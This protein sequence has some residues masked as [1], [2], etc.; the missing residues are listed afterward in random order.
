MNQRR[1]LGSLLGIAIGDAL[2]AP[3][4]GGPPPATPLKHY[5]SGGRFGLP[6]GHFT[7]DTLQAIAIARSLI[8]CRGFSAE[9]AMR[10]LLD[11]FLSAGHLF[12]PTSS[13]VF[14]LITGGGSI[15][16]AVIE[17]HQRNGGSRTNGSV[18]RGFPVGIY[19]CD[20]TEVY[21]ISMECSSLTHLDP[22]AGES[23]AFANLMVSRLCRGDRRSSAYKKAIACCRIPEVRHVLENF[24]AYRPAPSLDALGALHCALFHLMD[25]ES[26]EDALYRAVN[27]GGDADTIGAICGA[28]AGACWGIDGIPAH[29]LEGLHRR[30]EIMRLAEDLWSVSK[31]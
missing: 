31:G 13:T 10:R 20:P 22:V 2:G 28:L 4:E 24:R 29:L 21:R 23:S 6:A 19:Y 1:A 11:A 3:L 9:D 27:M 14:R 8:V 12:G 15:R 7:D 25:A 26:F 16:E 5:T 30:H 18:M 17:A